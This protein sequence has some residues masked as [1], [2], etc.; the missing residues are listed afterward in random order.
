MAISTQLVELYALTQACVLVKGK[1]ANS[2]NAI[3]VA[4]NLRV[5]VKQYDFL[6]S[7]EIKNGPY[8]QELLD[9]ILL[10]VALAIIKLSWHS[11]LDSLEAKEN[12]P[13]DISMRNAVLKGTRSSQTFFMT[14]RYI[15]LGDNLEKTGS[16]AQYWL[17]KLKRK[18]KLN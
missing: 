3:G 10:P 4:H 15:S 13:A 8:V 5:L 11:K 7:V 2:L 16:E 14:Q 9:V 12:H 17:Q 18:Q 1:I 6:S